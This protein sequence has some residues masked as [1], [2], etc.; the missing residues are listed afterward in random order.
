M[1]TPI[2][3]L[4][5]IA[6]MNDAPRKLV[7]VGDSA[8]A[9]IA[10]EYFTHDSP[11]DVVAFTVDDAY[12]TRDTLFDLPVVPFGNVSELYPPTEHS[13]FVAIGYNQLNRLRTRFV[14]DAKALGY[15]L[16]SYVS[17]RAFVWRNVT[18]GEHCFIFENNVV[19]PFVT[20]GNNVVLWS[21]NHIG[22]HST[23]R[24][25]V[26]FAS[27]VVLSGF[28]DVG[29][30]CFVGVNATIANNVTIAPDGLLGA[31]CMILRDTEPNR[32]YGAKMTTPVEKS[33]R[34]YF[35]VPEDMA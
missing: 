19:Q 23:I 26:F 29:E 34:A 9:E 28:C 22:H 30:N 16:A 13:I 1:T 20:I 11:Y 6:R 5:E 3:P 8:I 24:D 31:G 32:I 21:G 7:I 27:H 4:P 33:A 18:L 35:K 14:R 17:S 2:V 10:Y 25:N 15:A 12:L